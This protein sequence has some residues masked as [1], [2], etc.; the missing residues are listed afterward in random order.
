M[1]NTETLRHREEKKILD[2][3]CLCDSVLKSYRIWLLAFVFFCA[4]N[5]FA[6]LTIYFKDG[7]SREVHKI[8]FR[9][10]HAEL[11][12]TDGNVV[13]VA[14]EKIDLP[15]SGIG[16]PVGTYGTSK[17]TGE[18]TLSSK[19]EVLGSPFR[20]AR[21]RE[22][23]ESSEKSATVT[24]SIG[25]MAR[26]DIVKVVGETTRNSRPRPEDFFDNKDL[27]Y[28]PE[29]N[30][31]EFREKDLDHAFV[32]VYKNQ[33]GTYGKRLF[34]AVTFNSHFKFE[35]KAKAAAPMPEY[36]I[37]PDEKDPDVRETNPLA[38]PRKSEPLKPE[39]S[40]DQPAE[41]AV[42][43]SDTEEAAEDLSTSSRRRSWIAYVTFVL[44][45]AALGLGAWFLINHSQKPFID[46]SKFSRYEEDL[47]EFEIAIWLKNGKTADQLMEICLKKF[48]QDNPPVLNIC[49]RILKGAQKG[50]MV[51]SI[52][53]QSGRSMAEAEKIH[54]QIQLQIER[55]RS[56]IR[57]VAHKTGIQPA[58]PPVEAA[59]KIAATVAPQPQS[60][61]P[62]KQTL[63]VPPPLPKQT[64]GAAP[65]AAEQPASPTTGNSTS[66][67][68]LN[69][70][71]V[72]GTS[73]THLIEP[74]SPMRS[75]TDL[76]GYANT[77][78][79]QI[80]FLSSSEEK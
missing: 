7:S 49:N 58:K 54:D 18:R 25:S 61:S 20:Q 71:P 12:G 21:L 79:N 47:R 65:V 5:A 22:E 32:V 51:P 44:V 80:G 4:S 36:P 75:A 17:V 15:S 34:D 41:D 14:V 2:S 31:Y 50:L 33:D 24:T 23:W 1:L 63:P 48:Y 78:L 29:S 28:N 16:S 8:T 74:D 3:L 37:I 73:N 72:E 10:S 43:Q 52:A 55:I 13:T 42:S 64:P 38:A 56:L 46:T 40:H 77:V 66:S 30:T 45:V 57:E 67:V 68:V 19:K 6:A 60:V 69:P 9:G 35:E 76:P 59:A 39:P 26:G 53:K 70:A 62:A 27:L 11:Y